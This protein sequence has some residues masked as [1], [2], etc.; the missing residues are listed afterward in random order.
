MADMGS[1]NG[2]KVNDEEIQD[3]IQ[4]HNGDILKIGVTELMITIDE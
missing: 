2:T 3:R 1:S 4:L